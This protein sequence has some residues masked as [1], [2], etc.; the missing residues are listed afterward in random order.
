[1]RNW[2]DPLARRCEKRACKRIVRR[3]LFGFVSANVDEEAGERVS[4]QVGEI[5]VGVVDL[6]RQLEEELVDVG[7]DRCKNVW[8]VGRARGERRREEGQFCCLFFLSV[9]LIACPSGLQRR[10][11]EGE[12][13]GEGLTFE[14]VEVGGRLFSVNL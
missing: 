10:K 4:L 3:T 5:R 13:E 6:S 1:M 11:G 9:R 8:T 12:R 14:L 2:R 7:Q